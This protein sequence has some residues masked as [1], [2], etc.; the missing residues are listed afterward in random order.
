MKNF[1]R[2][3]IKRSRAQNFVELEKAFYDLVLKH[4]ILSKSHRHLQRS[5]NSINN[6][7]PR[8]YGLDV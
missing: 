7:Q 2:K 6:N 1:R 3:L 8:Y 5:V 4:N